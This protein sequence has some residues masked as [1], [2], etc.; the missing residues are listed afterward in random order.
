MDKIIGFEGTDSVALLPGFGY[1]YTLNGTK[2]PLATVTPYTV[3]A[4]FIEGDNIVTVQLLDKNG[5]TQSD[6]ITTTINV[7]IA[8]VLAIKPTGIV[9]TDVP[10]AV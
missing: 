6:L 7:P 9:V 5:A 10:P 2:L 1:E 3:Q 8:T 4:A